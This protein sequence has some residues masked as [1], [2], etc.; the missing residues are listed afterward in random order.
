VPA[1]AVGAAAVL[2]LT[3]VALVG[4]VA[5][6]AALS[7]RRPHAAAFVS[8]YWVW[9]PVLAIG[10]L[11]AVLLWPVGPVMAAAAIAVVLAK[12]DLFGLPPR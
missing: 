7:A 2:V 4:R 11:L 3:A 10:T 12:P 6:V 5:L 9:F 8:R 1:F